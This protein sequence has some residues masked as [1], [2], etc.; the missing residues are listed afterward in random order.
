MIPKLSGPMLAPLS[1]GAPKQVVV[2]LH[3]YGSNGEDLIGLAPSWQPI[4]PDALFVSP[5]A[6]EG[7]P[8]YPSGFQWFAIDF[9]GDRVSGRQ[10]GLEAAAPV[11]VQFLQD[12]WAQTGLGAKDTI[13]AGFSQGAMMALH[14]G[15]SLPEPLMGVIA[16]SGA[17]VPPPGFGEAGLPKPPVCIVHG[18]M[19]QVVDPALGEEANAA[20]VAAGYDVRYHVSRGVGHGISPDGL[21]FASDFIAAVSAPK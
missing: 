18:D 2:L 5:N 6:H 13:V 12:A 9:D 7:L 21:G 3:G 14:A 8:G 20:L 19:D 1:G 16:F 17:F 4:L 10:R 11:L 15:L